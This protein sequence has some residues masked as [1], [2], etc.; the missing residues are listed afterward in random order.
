MHTHTHAQHTTYTHDIH[1]HTH[2]H[3]HTHNTCTHMHTHAHTL[4]QVTV[5]NLQCVETLLQ[6]IDHHGNIL[7]S[8]WLLVMTA[9]QVYC[10]LQHLQY[11]CRCYLYLFFPAHSRSVWVET[12]GHWRVSAEWHYR[13]LLTGGWGKC[14]GVIICIL[15]ECHTLLVQVLVSLDKRTEISEITDKLANLFKSTQ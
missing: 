9:V 11:L 10:S 15:S 4:A 2:M 12:T 3:A 6:I 8:A 7:D 1:V 5:K 14:I 13:E